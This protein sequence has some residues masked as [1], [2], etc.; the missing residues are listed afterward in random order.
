MMCL[1]AEL[2][3]YDLGCIRVRDG[4]IENRPVEFRLRLEAMYESGIV[5][6]R[7]RDGMEWM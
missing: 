3:G 6:V 7:V 1:C 5:L 4:G 2:L